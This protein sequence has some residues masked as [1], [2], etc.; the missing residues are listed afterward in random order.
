VD[1]GFER[2]PS[3]NVISW[4]QTI[5]HTPHWNGVDGL[6]IKTLICMPRCLLQ[7]KTILNRFWEKVV[8]HSN[9]ILKFEQGF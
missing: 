2:Y 7:A 9:C 4:Q 5:P 3:Q 1:H 6:K 8:A